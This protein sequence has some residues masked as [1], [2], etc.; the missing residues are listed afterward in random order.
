MMNR[1]PGKSDLSELP[2]EPTPKEMKA[3]RAMIRKLG[4]EG[5]AKLARTIDANPP[6][7]RSSYWG[8]PFCDDFPSADKWNIVW[9]LEQYRS[10]DGID[11]AVH[12]LYDLLESKKDQNRL[13]VKKPD[14]YQRWAKAIKK[15]YYS[16]RKEVLAHAR[17]TKVTGRRPSGAKKK[18]RHK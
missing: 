12:D 8:A 17:W 4:R 15:L 10:K 9:W 2:P 6:S 14:T 11:D 7:G 3:L 18:P 5:V 1:L 13:T 16:H